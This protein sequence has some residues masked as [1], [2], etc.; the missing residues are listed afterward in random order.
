MDEDLIEK[1]RHHDILAQELFYKKYANKMFRICYRYIGNE[2]ETSEILNDGFYKVFVQIRSF[3]EG[4]IQ[5]LIAWMSKIMV[6][7]CLQCIRMRKKI[8]FVNETEALAEQSLIMPDEQIVAEDYY[9][10]IR[11]LGDSYRIVF[12]L[13]VMEGYS[14]KDI[15]KMLNI[16]ENTSRS[17][18][19]RARLE[20]KRK[21]EKKLLL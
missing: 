10:L 20:L 19:L 9:E 5:G 3:R 12:N 4:G 18:L 15:S 16:P 2:V 13:F 21:I 11:Q 6:N 7:E 1:L 8:L 17:F 14:H